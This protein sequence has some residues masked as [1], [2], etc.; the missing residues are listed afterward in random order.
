MKNPFLKYIM[1]EKREDIFHSSVY[2]K[3]QNGGSMGSTSS[4][5]FKDRMQIDK[6]RQVVHSYGESQVANS[7]YG[8][9]PRA[10]KYVPPESK[11]TG[12]ISA[13]RT[14]G[15]TSAA[16][17]PAAPRPSFTPTIKPNLGK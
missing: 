7:M 6:N 13:S 11:S 8:N 10:K 17:R 16:A 2:G 5:S 15:H 1:K 14:A 9:G 4:E 12:K 3:A